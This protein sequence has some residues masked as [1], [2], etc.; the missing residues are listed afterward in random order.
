MKVTQVPCRGAAPWPRMLWTGLPLVGSGSVPV[1]KPWRAPGPGRGAKSWGKMLQKTSRNIDI[2]LAFTCVW[3][4]RCDGSRPWG[5]CFGRWTG[6][7]VAQERSVRVWHSQSNLLIFHIVLR[8][9]FRNF[10]KH[11]SNLKQCG[12]C[13]LLPEPHNRSSFLI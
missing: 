12:L 4:V 3:A 13:I 5:L 11:R 2:A 8:H 10:C 7:S 6:V 1:G 9:N